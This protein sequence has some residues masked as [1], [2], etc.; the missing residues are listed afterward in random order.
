MGTPFPSKRRRLTPVI[1]QQPI[2]SIE[3]IKSITAPTTMGDAESETLKVLSL[4]KFDPNPGA[5]LK[6]TVITKRKDEL[7]TALRA[8]PHT[9]D[10]LNEI[11]ANFNQDFVGS[12]RPQSVA[13]LDGK[14]GS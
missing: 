11:V 7:M 10:A 13:D 5:R 12:E 3:I 14:G 9:E 4:D 6:D 8:G 1:D 2:D